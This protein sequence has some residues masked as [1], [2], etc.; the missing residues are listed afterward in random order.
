MR[1]GKIPNDHEWWTGL[2]VQLWKAKGQCIYG[3]NTTGCSLGCT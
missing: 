2:N 1:Q 3:I